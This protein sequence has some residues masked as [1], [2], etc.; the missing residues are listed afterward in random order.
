[1]VIEMELKYNTKIDD[2]LDKINL[3]ILFKQSCH[4]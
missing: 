4:Q 1:M 2:D 3:V